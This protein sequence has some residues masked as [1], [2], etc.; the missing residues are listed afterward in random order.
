M[1]LEKAHSGQS[2]RCDKGLAQGLPDGHEITDMLHGVGDG[3]MERQAAVDENLS[4]A[5][6]S[7]DEGVNQM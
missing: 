4:D 5:A 6:S 7:S 3:G 1:R 2:G